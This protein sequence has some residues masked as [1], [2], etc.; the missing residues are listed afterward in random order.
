MLISVH[1]IF[2]QGS[3]M[4]HG[5]LIIH[6]IMTNKLGCLWFVPFRLTV[7]SMLNQWSCFLVNIP[8][9]KQHL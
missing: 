2:E 1:F 4:I 8:Q 9:A 3:I 6:V 7:I 5:I